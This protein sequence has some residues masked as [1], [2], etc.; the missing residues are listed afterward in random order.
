MKND[1][2]TP[3]NYNPNDTPLV[4]IDRDGPKDWL[5]GA[6]VTFNLDIYKIIK[7]NPT[8]TLKILNNIKFNVTVIHLCPT[9]GINQLNQTIFLSENIK[10]YVSSR[11]PCIPRFKISQRQNIS[12]FLILYFVC[13]DVKYLTW[14]NIFL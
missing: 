8:Q 10:K 5:W 11:E 2:Y 9:F 1:T 13:S 3:T 7:R 12:N 14:K 6:R 4:C